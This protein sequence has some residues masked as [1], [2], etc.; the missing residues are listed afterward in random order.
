[1][2]TIQLAPL[3]TPGTVDLGA[4]FAGLRRRKRVFLAA[5]LVVN[6]IAIAITASWIVTGSFW[7]TRSRTGCC[8]RTDSPRS[9]R[10][11]PPTQ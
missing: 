7:T 3:Q 9:P 11:T 5:L 2:E 4:A 8:V 1:M 10:S 6:A